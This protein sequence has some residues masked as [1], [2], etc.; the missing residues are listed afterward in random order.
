VETARRRFRIAFFRAADLVRNLTE[1]RDDRAFILLHRRLWRVDLL[2][3]DEL[4]F[5]PFERAGGEL[6]F[7][8]ISERHEIRSTLITTDL[9]FGEWAQVFWRREADHCA[10][11]PPEAP[12]PH[13]NYQGRLLPDTQT[14]EGG[15]RHGSVSSAGAT[16]PRPTGVAQFLSVANTYSSNSDRFVGL[17]V[18]EH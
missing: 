14:R 1:D 7:D 3:L 16:L 15:R 18:S 2:I 5:V 10:L 12:R 6:L 13:P 8:V 17:R 9:S 11:G 4:G